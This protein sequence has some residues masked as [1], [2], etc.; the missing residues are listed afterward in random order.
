MARNRLPMTNPYDPA[1]FASEPR[2]EGQPII[3]KAGN[4]IEPPP[5]KEYRPRREPG[6]EFLRDYVGIEDSKPYPSTRGPSI[7]Y[8]PVTAR[9]PFKV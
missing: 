4:Y 3:D 7:P 6:T 1:R 5:A 8:P 2:P 9:K